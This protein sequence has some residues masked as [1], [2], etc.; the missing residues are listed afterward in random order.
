MSEM[1]NQEEKNELLEEFETLILSVSKEVIDTSVMDDLVLLRDNLTREMNEFS[2]KADRVNSVIISIDNILSQT[3]A[4]MTSAI[5]RTSGELDEFLKQSIQ[6]LDEKMISIVNE[7]NRILTESSE[8][9]EEKFGSV[10]QDIDNILQKTSDNISEK[11]N[12]T[13]EEINRIILNSSDDM[14]QNSVDANK[15]MQ[16]TLETATSKIHESVAFV[17]ESLNE[18]LAR[19]TESM[20]LVIQKTTERLDGLINSTSDHFSEE[21]KMIKDYLINSDKLI[22]SNQDSITDIQRSIEARM[23]ETLVKIMEQSEKSKVY[24]EDAIQKINGFVEKSSKDIYS[25]NELNNTINIKADYI[26]NKV[27]EDQKASSKRFMIALVLNIVTIIS[28]L[29]LAGIFLLRG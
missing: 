28:V 11:F 1:M 13:V 19:N 15:T 29:G 7:L 10:T 12:Q 17:S 4:N 16:E 6:N 3:S 22:R 8:Q 9:V 5:K 25:M 24:L 20:D 14:K 23:N 2:E 21:I 27:K 18:S 26:L